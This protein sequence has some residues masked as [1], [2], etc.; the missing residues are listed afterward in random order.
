MAIPE[1]E[2][3]FG[4]YAPTRG[5]RAILWLGGRLP[6]NYAGAR[7]AGWLR[8]LLQRTADGPLDREVLGVR[9]R[10]HLNGNAT[11]RRLAVTPHFFDPEELALLRAL[12]TPGFQFVDM[13]A[14]VGT[15]SLVIEQ[16]AGAGARILAIEP[17][18]LA[19]TRLRANMALN[20]SA[21]HVAPVAVSDRDGEISLQMDERNLGATSVHEV[22]KGHGV[23]IRRMVPTRPL[24]ALVRDAGFT[25]IDALKA[26]IEG[27]E[28][29]ALMPFFASAPR[30]LWPR[31]LIIENSADR[32]RS[33]LRGELER[34]GYRRGMKAKNLI[35][36]LEPGAD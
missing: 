9:M 10:L 15:Y 35:Y 25:A 27:A 30:E 8:S 34:R 33:D 1:V 36:R 2:P 20:Q 24:H 29:L 5:Q 19:I 32:W 28:D 12:A 17:H 6:R 3:P 18:P 21:I 23:P 26:D 14:N 11:E 16:I 13:G 7:L 22:Y 31:L 4:A